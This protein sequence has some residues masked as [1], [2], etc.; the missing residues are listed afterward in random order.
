M[1]K[2]AGAARGGGVRS[3][4]RGLALLV[5]MNRR[6]LASVMELARDT[7]LPRPT[8][9]RLLESL[10]RT[11]FVARTN[12]S[13]RYRL[14]RQV[15]AL[16][17]GFTDDEW[18]T[19]VAAPLMAEFTQKLVW[20]L[21]LMTFDE[22]RMLVRETTHPAS[23]LS[24]DYGMVGRRLPML[25]TAAGRAY[26]AFASDSER[27]AILD[28]LTHSDASEDRPAKEAAR[29]RALFKSIRAQGYALQDREINPRT[30]GIAVPISFNGRVAGSISVILISSA[31][32]IEEAVQR[33]V[34]PL[35]IIASKISSQVRSKA[36]NAPADPAA[37]TQYSETTPG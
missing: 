4:E 36:I 29:L 11:G 30:T 32:T 16:S 17:D 1:N 21:A 34:E 37:T 13:D 20:P 22:G 8:V 24:I 7:H 9:Y 6:K 12:S 31:M 26:L 25:L 3:L 2:R 33:F 5:A 15:R 23:S 18:I 27:A 19:E 10:S 28:M 14:A 35:Q